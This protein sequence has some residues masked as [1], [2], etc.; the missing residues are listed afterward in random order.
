MNKNRRD[1]LRSGAWAGLW[2][3]GLPLSAGA[4]DASGAELSLDGFIALS[5]RWCGCSDALLD[6][7]FAARLLERLRALGHGAELAR[8][9]SAAEAPADSD[10]DQQLRA[11]LL[12]A[13]FAGRLPNT[14]GN[15]QAAEPDDFEY[16]L[17]WSTV[18]FLHLPG[19]CGGAHG[20]W[21][22]PSG[23]TA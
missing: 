19:T 17:V 16:A 12:A 15:T 8:A 14:G 11:Q 2:L 23:E 18:P 13:W 3:G 10:A 9:M 20:Y 22:Q 21:A 5:A 1:L 6:R 7:G 4:F